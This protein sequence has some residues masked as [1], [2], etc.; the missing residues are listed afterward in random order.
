MS[1]VSN[2]GKSICTRYHRVWDAQ[3][4]AISN[5][6]TVL[7]PAKGTWISPAGVLFQER[8][9]PVRVRCNRDDILTIAEM[10]KRY[11]DQEAVMITRI[12]DECIIV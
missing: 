11:Y 2:E 10:T 9:I 3:V 12:S 7:V 8:M 1:T 5:G 6:L 4:R